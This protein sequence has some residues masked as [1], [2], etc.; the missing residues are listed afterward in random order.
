MNKTLCFTLLALSL[1][2]TELSAAVFTVTS[3]DNLQSRLDSTNNGDTVLLEPGTYVGNFVVNNSIT[4][5]GKEGAL[6][7]AG[8]HGNAITLQQL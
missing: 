3:N 8:G 1:L 2:H 5:A 7:D 6:I 4:L